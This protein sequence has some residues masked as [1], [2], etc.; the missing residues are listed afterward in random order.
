MGLF[1]FSL[2]PWHHSIEEGRGLFI[3]YLV[4]ARLGYIF[5]FPSWLLLTP[6]TWGFSVQLCKGWSS[7]SPLGFYWYLPSREGCDYLISLPIWLPL[8]F[9]GEVASLLLG[10]GE[11]LD[12]SSGCVWDY[13]SREGKGT[14]LLPD[15]CESPSSLDG[16]HCHQRG[17][18]GS[19]RPTRMRDLAPYSAF[20]N[21]FLW[22]DWGN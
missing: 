11:R 16:I 2:C 8:T 5:W 3:A 10:I 17:E 20:S 19:Y 4:I 6:K 14:S 12:S 15:G 22:G 9:W 13:P 7:G 1:C 21:T 18:T